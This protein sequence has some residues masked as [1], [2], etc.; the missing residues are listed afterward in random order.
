MRLLQEKPESAEEAIAWYRVARA[1][2][3]KNLADVRQSFP[4]ADLVGNVLIF[5]LR[6]NRYRLIVRAAFRIKTLFVKA[7]LTH[8]QYDRG[9]WK[10]WARQS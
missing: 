6:H 5:N 9:E 3:W 1:A 10:K 2:D 4:S 8:R 7:M